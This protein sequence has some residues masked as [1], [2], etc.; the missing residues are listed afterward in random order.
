[1]YLTECSC[2]EHYSD[3]NV[4]QRRLQKVSG[5]NNL[6]QVNPR[7]V[8]GQKAFGQ[9]SRLKKCVQNPTSKSLI[10]CGG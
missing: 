9:T 7:R 4:R 10:L 5:V 2:Q 6:A 1:M 3:L 8:M